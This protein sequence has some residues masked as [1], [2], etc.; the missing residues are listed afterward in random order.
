MANGSLDMIRKTGEPGTAPV[1]LQAFVSRESGNFRFDA[2]T[3]RAKRAG[4]VT[5]PLATAAPD[6]GSSTLVI[7]ALGLYLATG[8][9]VSEEDA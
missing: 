5:G 1:A 7:G 4:R 8:R 3:R 9:Y 2:G 6:H